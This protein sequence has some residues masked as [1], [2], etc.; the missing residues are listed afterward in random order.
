MSNLPA[1]YGFQFE[2]RLDNNVVQ[3]STP[4]MDR[5]EMS[6]NPSSFQLW[7]NERNIPANET[8]DYNNNGIPD[9][10]EFTIG[11]NSLPQLQE[12]GTLTIITTS[13]ALLDGR[14]PELQYGSDLEG[15]IPATEE[16]GEARI[17]QIRNL[18][19][20]DIETTYQI[21][22]EEEQLFWRISVS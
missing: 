1:G 20:G 3:G 10:I 9:L 21:N 15:W 7:A 2:L 8:G 18:P 6:F 13:E 17:M 16:P 19:N 5:V 12:D 11:Q 4:I 22:T 14:I